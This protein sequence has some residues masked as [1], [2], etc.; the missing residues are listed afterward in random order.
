MNAPPETPADE[1]PRPAGRGTHVVELGEDIYVIAARHG[2]DPDALW[3][4]AAN[5]AL[6]RVRQHPGML[7]PGDA[8]TIPRPAAV[9]PPTVSP[10]GDHSFRLVARPLEC[11]VRLQR[12]GR[13]WAGA[14]YTLVG[15]AREVEGVADGAGQI[16]ALVAA[17]DRTSVLVIEDGRD[18]EVRYVVNLGTASTDHVVNIGTTG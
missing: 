12:N 18:P 1:A 15:A 9:R 2:V 14:R 5:A 13:P 3:Q 6:R 10:G 11:R 17:H 4:H 16:T 7:L 8:V